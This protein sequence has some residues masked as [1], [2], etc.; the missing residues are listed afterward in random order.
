MPICTKEELQAAQ[1]KSAE[2][3]MLEATK[4]W[5]TLCKKDGKQYF[6]NKGIAQVTK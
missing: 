5:K 1:I 3:P 6:L 2:K 4:I